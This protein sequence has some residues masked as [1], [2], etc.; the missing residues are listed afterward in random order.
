M[1]RKQLV[2]D[3]CGHAEDHDKEKTL[4]QGWVRLEI[5][6]FSYKMIDKHWCDNCFSSAE[7]YLLQHKLE[8][9]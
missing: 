8:H 1:F 3:S 5:S 7:T 9:A 4:P 6:G 2:C